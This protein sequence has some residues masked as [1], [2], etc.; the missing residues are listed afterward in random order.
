MLTGKLTVFVEE[1]GMGTVEQTE[2]VKRHFLAEIE[3]MWRDLSLFSG[4]STDALKQRADGICSRI[5]GI[6]EAVAR[7]RGF[8]APVREERMHH[9]IIPGLDDQQQVKARA[10]FGRYP[11]VSVDDSTARVC[12][13]GPPLAHVIGRLGR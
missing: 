1:E 10:V 5:S 7:N 8:D 2:D 3:A 9:S 6:R 11:W 13:A 12:H 4:E